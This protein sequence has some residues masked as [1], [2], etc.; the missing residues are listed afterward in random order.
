MFYEN[1][2]VVMTI[3]RL[4]KYIEVFENQYLPRLKKLKN[5]Y[6]NNN[7]TISH[8]TYTDITLPNWQIS[9]AWANYISNISSNYFIGKGCTYNS[10]NEQMLLDVNAILKYNDEV[11]VNNVLALNQSIFGYA[12]ELMYLDDNT[13]IR[14]M[15][16]DNKQIILIY[17]DSLESNLLYAIRFYYTKD[18]MFNSQKV[19]NVELYSRTGIEYYTEIKSK[20]TLVDSKPHYFKEVPI[21]TFRN[22][23]D[24]FGDFE[25]VIPLIDAYDVLASDSLNE[26]ESFNAAYLWFKNCG[27]SDK[28]IIEMKKNR[29]IITEDGT[30]D[31]AGASN[32]SWLIKNGNPV[33]TESNKSRVENDIHKFSFVEDMSGQAAKSHT[34]ATQARLSMLGLEQLMA[35]K[36]SHFRQGL[37]RRVELI[38]NILA[39]K[40]TEYNFTDLTISFVRNIPQDSTVIADMISKLRG[41]A[42]DETLL[43]QLPFINDVAAEKERLKAQ[44]ELNSYNLFT[45]LGGALTDEQ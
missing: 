16:L 9:N 36:E 10:A 28:D 26:N 37:I 8:R 6:D 19:L 15:P 44:N 43:E 31:G 11:T 22:N 3:Q 24:C 34:S 20:L 38:C 1:K 23:N 35:N 30:D 12:V 17:D 32:I 18:I 27:L 21:N 14:F 45:D 41:L 5:Y 25:K 29:I 33:E 40:G 39:L 7:D 42:S 4:K 2:S 13:N